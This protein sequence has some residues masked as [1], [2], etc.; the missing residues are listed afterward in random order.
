MVNASKILTV[1]YGTFSCT[2]EG[3]DDPFSTMRSI[4][5]YFRDLAADDR[6]FGAEPPTPDAEMLHRIAE[7]EINRRV[8]AKVKKNGIVLRQ[9]ERDAAE[10]AMQSA[11]A[12]L[13]AP[14]KSSARAAKPAP[15]P[16]E[17][18]DVDAGPMDAATGET[19]AEK[20]RRIRAAVARQHVEPQYS[21][22]F[23]EDED[24]G[25]LFSA[26]P[27]ETAF[28]A[29]DS[30]PKPEA[31]AEAKQAPAPEPVEEQPVEDEQAAP[32]DAK[33]ED[34]Q[35]EEIA[36]AEEAT[37]EAGEKSEDVS[38]DVI[39]TAPEQSVE[40][41][42]EEAPEDVE[43]DL[44]AIKSMTAPQAAPEEVAETAEEPEAELAEAANE[45]EQ[46]AADVADDPLLAELTAEEAPE[47]AQP[48]EAAEQTG[49]EEGETAE[50]DMDELSTK[51][52]ETPAEAEE[53]A[54]ET[55]EAESEETAEAMATPD[56]ADEAAPSMRARIVKMSRA[57]FLERYVEVSEEVVD[58][59]AEDAA[60]GKAVTQDDIRASLGETGLS[61]EDEDDL[62][63]EL[64]A[65]EHD[66]TD[67]DAV[68]AAPQEDAETAESPAEE[69][70]E[71]AAA[72]A[73][74][75][76]KPAE[77]P[78]EI[79]ATLKAAVAPKDGGDLSVTRLLRQ[80]DS[81]LQ[82][83]ESSR[84]RSAIAHLKAAVAAV[85]ADGGRAK[86]D[87]EA[88]DA[89]A[90]D[91]YR[92]DLAR[93]VRPEGGT[94]AD[95]A[96]DAG[97]EKP[98]AVKPEPVRLTDPARPISRPR[99]KMPPLMLVSEQRIDKPVARDPDAEP[100]RP[101]RVQTDDEAANADA[102]AGDLQD[103]DGESGNIF[104]AADDFSGY[105]AETGAEGVQ[106]LLEASAAF[107]TL[108]EGQ[109]FNSR[110]QIMQRMLRYVPE[111]TVTREEGLR[112]FGVLLREGRLVR[113]QRGQF[114][115][116]ENS[117][118]HEQQKS[119]ANDG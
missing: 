15:A 22:A 70:G 58:A 50:I 105:V 93:V 98:A 40:A 35:A 107:G 75:G 63:S 7:R 81:E 76:E 74:A 77:S 82:D 6:Y 47:E 37:P 39:A 117:R 85:R 10:P 32:A 24:A 11:P 18:V 100:V 104:G 8:E 57:A 25:Q 108:V 88:E 66:T 96:G 71:D 29:E 19:V 3:F 64:F 14:A 106:E 9:V 53:T 41:F 111:G 61:P 72:E 43:I 49:V 102:D 103:A 21:G 51:L 87:D 45:A 20:L 112:A 97:D 101:R 116:P 110:P 2:L 30:E 114:V 13:D 94:D 5:E 59:Q 79:A 26:E 62:I 60:A 119:A 69:T 118:F 36:P 99:R 4:A 31:P 55:A 80:A 44:A 95:E 73:D 52:S 68:D 115:L 78:E 33:A 84:R 27:I 83:N 12:A 113:I 42:E 48:A 46:D 1:S 92:D 65:A 91:Q 17:A 90:M 56:S 67:E 34:A 38:E 54:A 23:A 28:Q 16:S 86:E 89:R 109:P